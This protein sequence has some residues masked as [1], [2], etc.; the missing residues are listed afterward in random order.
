MASN[1]IPRAFIGILLFTSMF[2]DQ[3][4]GQGPATNNE[5][6]PQ[7]AAGALPKKDTLEET[8]FTEMLRIVDEKF[9]SLSARIS[10]LER[11]V[12]SL[13]FYSIRQFR[14]IAESIEE[15][16][17]VTEGL[18]GQATKIDVDNRALKLAVSQ[19]GRDVNT[20]KT[21]NV[22]MF[23]DIANS[24]VYFNQNVEE[25]SNEVKRTIEST[26]KTAMAAAAETA[27]AGN[28]EDTAILI[29]YLEE[30]PRGVNCNVN[31]GP[32]EE[33]IDAR[34]AEMKRQTHNNFV[35][36]INA[37]GQSSEESE[38]EDQF[39][40]DGGTKPFGPKRE[41]EIEEER[42]R[43]GEMV[44]TL[45][46]NMTQNVME[47]TAYFR[48][49]G[50][51]IERLLTRTE[52]IS[53]EQ[54]RLRFDVLEAS[55]L[56]T[57]GEAGEELF[58]EI[59]NNLPG[60]AS[61]EDVD[62]ETD[63]QDVSDDAVPVTNAV[64]AST[65]S[66]VSSGTSSA[67]TNL[68]QT[69]KP[70]HRASSVN[71]LLARRRLHMTPRPVSSGTLPVKSS[72]PHE[73]IS[74]LVEL[75]KNGTQLLDVLT[76]LAQLSSSSMTKALGSLHDEV[77]RLEDLRTRINA[78]LLLTTGKPLAGVLGQ[79]AGAELSGGGFGATQEL[80]SLQ[81][82]TKTIFTIVEAI[83]SNTGWIPYIFHNMQHVERLANRTF[84]LA[85]K[86]VGQ[87][88]WSRPL[89]NEIPGVPEAQERRPGV[90]PVGE[91]ADRPGAMTQAEALD[92]IY[93]TNVRLKRIMP[94]L[95]RLLAEPEPLIALVEGKRATEGR[96]EVFFKGQW[97]SVCQG[98]MGHSE[99]SAICR[100]LGHSGG[101]LAGTGQFGH[102]TGQRW[103]LN[104]TCLGSMRCQFVTNPVPETAATCP[105]G[106]FS[107][108]CDHMLRM[109]P[110]PD[111]NDVNTGRIEM[112]HQ[113]FWLPV[114]A[115]GWSGYEARVACKQMG[116]RDGRE[117]ESPA[118]GVSVNTTV[119]ITGVGCNGQERSL[120]A[121]KVG[122]Y[123]AGECPAGGK[124]AAV[125]CQ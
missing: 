59:V 43:E 107:I 37:K 31:F 82:L 29:K 72:V 116:Y 54:T 16:T 23:D 119:W 36:L 42:R 61:H 41:E 121:C 35:D 97:H 124:P 93:E 71:A 13:N 51:M 103:A 25:K 84:E 77:V 90:V 122:S 44:M 96:V 30:M 55:G 27:C 2:S 60:V 40:G 73:S 22:R 65:A 106:D 89:G 110:I 46:A 12:N 52:S 64:E 11:S 83:A 18:R 26:V 125:R 7:N 94:A 85:K 92:V 56:L 57:R 50:S 100:H 76:D 114:C 8:L 91:E 102:G 14:E 34:F 86:S 101:I 62:G 80:R 1:H 48:H 67:P 24:I 81:N 118:E 38:D 112:H 5:T 53:E 117:F 109:E 17:T 9:D 49:T 3:V 39:D 88:Q 58:E 74:V 6:T 4:A 115:Y 98:D 120:D 28:G 87:L 47:A 69:S 70:L 95:T 32:L 79:T 78:G 66:S 99:A 104:M 111:V 10:V 68:S 105:N 15:S 113:G 123:A 75:A 108:I 33:R 20:I 21:D 63:S 19:I 45:L